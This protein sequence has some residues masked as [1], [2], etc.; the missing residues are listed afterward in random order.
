MLAVD[1]SN[2]DAFTRATAQSLKDQGL[3][4]IVRAGLPFERPG[5]VDISRNQL[6]IIRMVGVE[7]L[8]VYG[9]AYFD[10]ADPVQ[11]AESLFSLYSEYA[12]PWYWL[13][14]EANNLPTPEQNEDWLARCLDEFDRQLVYDEAGIYTGRWWW[15]QYQNMNNSTRFKARSLW[16]ATGDL[17]PDLQFVPFGG[18][19]TVQVEQYDLRGPDRDVVDDDWLNGRTVI[20]DPTVEDQLSYL[21]GLTHDVIPAV[22]RELEQIH[23]RHDDQPHMDAALKA[24]RENAAA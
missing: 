15:I 4:V 3:G 17:N 14:C 6:E 19:T 1:V 12:P 18:W 10:S 22:I 20:V 7:L 8:G 5:L 16:A 13:D 23:V 11:T 9:W 24:L 2:Y 21:G